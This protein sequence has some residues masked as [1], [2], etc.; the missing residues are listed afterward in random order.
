[1]KKQLWLLAAGG[2][3]VALVAFLTTQGRSAGQDKTPAPA[4]AAAGPVGE[5]NRAGDEEAIRK[6]TADFIKAVEKG[7]A[8][9]VA[10]AWT[11]G[12]EYISDDGTTIRGRAA[13]E[14]AYTKA[15]AKKD[16]PKVEITIESIRF[17]SKDTAIEEG[18]AKRYHN[19]E[20]PTASRYSVLHVHEGG[21]WLM[22]VLREWPHEGVGLRDLDWLI[23]TW[24]AKTDEAEVRTTYQWDAKK[25]AISCHIT[26]KGSD[27]NVTATQFLMKDPR[28]GQIR[29]WLFDDDGG[30]GD[31]TWTRDGKRWVIA[32]TGVQADGDELTA[33]NIL[34]PV[35][36]DT[37][38]WQST[39]RTLNGEELLNI[40]PVKV[41]RVK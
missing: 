8:K 3:L 24:E 29:S 20:H 32:A 1:M 11:E 41:R 37:F 16:R 39:E 15:F 30:F 7:D 2:V 17:P 23:G 36:K 13:I 5:A 4:K 6:A 40:P 14:A 10:A 9:A 31:G 25:N 26:I 33:T 34:T 35:D 18:Y 21:R 27:R 19:S 28:T 38:T 12:G 22:A